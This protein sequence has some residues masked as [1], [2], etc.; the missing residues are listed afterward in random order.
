MASRYDD[1]TTTYTPCF[2]SGNHDVSAQA[3]AY[4]RG[5][6]QS[7]KRNMERMAEAVPETDH[8]VLQN[9]LTHSS[10]DHQGVMNQV[11]KDADTWLGGE[12][13]TGLY[14]D[15]SAFTK[16]GKKSVGVARQWNGRLGKTDNCQV[17]VYGALGKDKHVSLIDARLYLPKEWL[18]APRRCAEAEIPR[19]NQVHKTKHDLALEIV[20]QARQR[21]V[22]F[23]WI[24]MDAFYGMSLNL[25]QAIDG[26]GEVFMAD[27]H[28]D[29]HI[30][31]TDPK[32]YL[33]QCPSQK[34]RKR[35]RYQSDQSATEVQVWTQSQP[36][37]A[38]KKKALRE[39]DKG[40][41]EV[42]VLHQPV[43]VWDK[44]SA[45]ASRWHLIVRRE[46]DSP[47]TLK[48]SLCNASQRT[49]I[50]KLARM[51][52]QRYWIERAFQDAKSHIGMGQYQARKWASWH[53]H[54][55][56]VMMAH[57]FMLQERMRNTAAYPLLSCYDIQI[58][59]AK[60][61]PARQKDEMD[62][63]ELMEERHRKRQAAIDSARER[64]RRASRSNRKNVIG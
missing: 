22:R 33:P 45:T 44:R 6:M 43:W 42:E 38:W 30:Y 27:I 56:L 18:D 34:G 29:R 62:V 59:L 7:E 60:T 12:V 48:Y 52:A 39:G 31:L 37:S 54:M 50:L 8:Q 15:E 61:L 1:Y 28:K 4:L 46:P 57:Q 9:F 5:L 2:R 14:I 20:A 41:L 3:R 25:L 35:Q 51:Q 55:A 21:S 23:E 19:A 58:L 16:K 40:K 47:S 26:Q 32:P 64:Q 17:A 63:L 11:S 13:G 53:R 10:W 36:E 24:G 49:S